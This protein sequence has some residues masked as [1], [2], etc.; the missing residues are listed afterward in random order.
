MKAAYLVAEKMFDIR[1][2]PDPKAPQDG[3]VMKVEACGICGGDLRRWRE[4]KSQGASNVILGHEVT[5]VVES[6]GKDVIGYQPGDRLAIAPDIHCGTCYYCQRAL[7]N[8]CDDLK[9]IGIS[10][11]YPGGYAEKLV[12]TGEVL[13]NG[14]VHRIP[15]NLSFL[16]AAL[17][18]P[19]SSVLA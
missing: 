6:A 11:D 18:E 14:I 9:L 3:L 7:Y 16:D 13:R 5:G 17:S 2:L 19:C 8:L 4:G 10:P 1:D 12:L 15:Q